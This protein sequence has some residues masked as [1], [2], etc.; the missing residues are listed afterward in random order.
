MA[1]VLEHD[2]GRIDQDVAAGR[3]RPAGHRRVDLAV[4][5]AD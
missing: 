5:Q 4:I 1:V 3:G 2:K